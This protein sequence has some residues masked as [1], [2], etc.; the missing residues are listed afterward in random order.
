MAVH[1][2]KYS[3]WATRVDR[4]EGGKRI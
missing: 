1:C 3:V 4:N 2:E